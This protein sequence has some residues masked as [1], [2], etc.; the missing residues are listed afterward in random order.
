M[1]MVVVDDSEMMRGLIFEIVEGIPWIE[2]VGEAR[3][4]K[5]GLAMIR[6]LKPDLVTLDITMPG[7]GGIEVLK[8]LQEEGVA[9]RVFVLTALNSAEIRRKC[10]ELGQLA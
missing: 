9:V 6:S 1:R 2:I 3:D 8:V 4:G 5:E 7:M 10:F